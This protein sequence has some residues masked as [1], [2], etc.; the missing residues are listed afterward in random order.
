[1]SKELIDRISKE[2]G[3]PK[4]KAAEQL[5]NVFQA[6]GLEL[7]EKDSVSIKDFGSFNKSRFRKKTVLFKKEYMVDTNV[8]RFN[9]FKK[10]KTSINS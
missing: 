2:T 10:L 7:Q 5:K 6:I 1:M 3:L 4:T 8:V 9:I